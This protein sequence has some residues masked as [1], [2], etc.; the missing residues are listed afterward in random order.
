MMFCEYR[1]YNGYVACSR[2]G[3]RRARA[4]IRNC[5]VKEPPRPRWI[6]A[7]QRAIDIYEMAGRVPAD[8][9]AVAGVPRSG[10]TPASM[11]AE[12][13][14]L[15]MFIMH[16]DCGLQAVPHGWRLKHAAQDTGRLLVVDDTV[17]SG[18]SLERLR[19]IQTGRECLWAGV[20]VNPEQAGKVQLIG[21][22]LPLPHYLEW[23]L[24]NSIYTSALATDIDGILCPDPDPAFSDCAYERY[25]QNAPIRQR[26]VKVVLPLIATGRKRTFRKH[27]E[28]WFEK[29][30]IRYEQL[31]F[32]SDDWELK[33]PGELKARAYGDSRAT[34]FVE[35]DPDQ[36]RLIADRTQKRVICPQTAE[37]WN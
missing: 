8:V 18:Q 6:S 36:A 29:H 21:Q 28:E 24:F 26:P 27:T 1:Q 7:T 12:L 11:I 4:V 15:P 37:V 33:N 23:N 20:Y 19:Q 35:S 2:C 13:L 22:I 30:G 16:E 10:L 25:L 32:P 9:T 34:I 17:A 14:H 5:E 31:V 3:N